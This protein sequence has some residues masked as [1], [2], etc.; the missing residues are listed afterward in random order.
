MSALTFYLAMLMLGSNFSTTAVSTEPAEEQIA[1]PAVVQTSTI[2]IMDE[3]QRFIDLVNKERA[4][5]GIKELKVDPVLVK[6]AREHSKEMADKGYFDHISPTPGRRTA[7]DRYIAE[8]GHKPTWALIGE[9]LF[10]CSITDVNRGHTCLMNSQTHR[11]NI[12]NDRFIRIGVGIYKS[13][14]GELWVTE[15]FVSSID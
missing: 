7:L 1:Q 15:M 3:E 13:D 12:L 5:R 4:E 9:N 6:I 2:Q 14:D 8:I 10:Y 11:D